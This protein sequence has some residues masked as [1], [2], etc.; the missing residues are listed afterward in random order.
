MF[1]HCPPALKVWEKTPFRQMT[2][3]LILLCVVKE[4]LKGL[5]FENQRALSRNLL[6]AMRPHHP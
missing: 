3:I 4:R 6:L 5:H 2:L 1:D